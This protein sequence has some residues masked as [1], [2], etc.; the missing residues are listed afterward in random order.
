MTS[1][2]EGVRAELREAAQRAND[3]GTPGPWKIAP[4]RRIARNGCVIGKMDESADAA[5][6]A[7]ANP[8]AV[9][10]LLA[11]RDVLAARL[12]RVRELHQPEERTEPAGKY[13]RTA[14]GFM[15]TTK[16]RTYVVC[17]ECYGWEDAERVPW[18]CPTA[19]AMNEGDTD[20]QQQ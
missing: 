10:A 17:S 8:A 16:P 11:E 1:G 2:A 13:R 18:P 6:V 20:D 4:F 3:N 19:A 7:A 5:F 15:R 9:L 12:A 14:A